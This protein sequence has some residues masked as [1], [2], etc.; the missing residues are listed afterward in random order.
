MMFPQS[1]K[2]HSTIMMK[3]SA[4][5]RKLSVVKSNNPEMFDLR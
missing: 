2:L 5:E 4:T 3:R 1:R